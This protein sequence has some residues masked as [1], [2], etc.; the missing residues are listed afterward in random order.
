MMTEEN[1]KEVI[2]AVTKLRAKEEQLEGKVLVDSKQIKEFDSIFH[3]LENMTSLNVLVNKEELLRLKE[4]LAGSAP[5][6]LEEIKDV[7]ASEKEIASG[8]CKTFK[9]AKDL[10]ADLHKGR[11]KVS[12]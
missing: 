3:N 6:S 5:L 4:L 9:N 8:K 10:I 2:Q 7:E 1:I 12:V 11:K